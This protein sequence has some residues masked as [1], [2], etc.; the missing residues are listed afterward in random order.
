LDDDDRRA[1]LDGWFRVYA[2]RVLA[3]LLHRTDE[4]T[5]QDVL[6]EVFVIAFRK[7]AE[8]PEPPTGWLF[9][10]ARRVLANRSRGARRHDRLVA[11]LVAGGRVD[12]DPNTA[13]LADAFAQTLAV[14]SV[15]DREALTLSGW[16]GLTPAEAAEALG[17][18]PA[19]YAVR[20]HRARK[21]LTAALQEA[22]YG[23][24][25]PAGTLAAALHD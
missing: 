22:G 5:A 1:L 17:C 6:Q 13:E 4:Q 16:Y 2:H 3:Y 18:S 19:T 21:R 11:Y 23:G 15:S 12:D 7:A 10:T 20:L 8:V 25:S 9:G 24:S 14:L